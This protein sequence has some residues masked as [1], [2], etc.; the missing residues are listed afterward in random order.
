M[1]IC[2]YISKTERKRDCIKASS[3]FCAASVI[4][5]EYTDLLRCESDL[6]GD[7]VNFLAFVRTAKQKH[8]IRLQVMAQHPKHPN[9]DS[10]LSRVDLIVSHICKRTPC[11]SLRGS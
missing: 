2:G 5:R 6:N 4:K 10:S 1:N 3:I 9:S 7:D 8:I 11:L